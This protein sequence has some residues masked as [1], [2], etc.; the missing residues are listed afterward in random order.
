MVTD[1]T[2]FGRDN[3]YSAERWAPAVDFYRR[4]LED[5]SD[6]DNLRSDPRFRSLLLEMKLDRQD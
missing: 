2:N 3:R 1:A 5:D 6:L 4:D